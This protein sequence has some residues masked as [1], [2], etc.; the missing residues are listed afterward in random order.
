MEER[1]STWAAD[2]TPQDAGDFTGLLD[3]IGAWQVSDG[4]HGPGREF[5]PCSK[6]DAY[7][8]VLAIPRTWV[9]MLHDWNVSSVFK[10]WLDVMSNKRLDLTHGDSLQPGSQTLVENEGTNI[11]M[12]CKVPGMLWQERILMVEWHRGKT[13]TPLSRPMLRW[14][15]RILHTL[16][17][18][19]LL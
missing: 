19:L 1:N 6:S 11:Q 10:H 15:K 3:V 2:S 13:P 4:R 14:T 8:L 12:R 9:R 16:N 7:L 5:R 17:E 18:P